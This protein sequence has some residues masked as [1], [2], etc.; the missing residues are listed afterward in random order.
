M[1]SKNPSLPVLSDVLISVSKDKK[2]LMFSATNLDLGANFTLKAKIEDGEE[3][4]AVKAGALAQFLTNTT[5]D[6][7]VLLEIK[8]NVLVVKTKSGNAKFAGSLAE[9]FPTINDLN[10]PVI[11]SLDGSKISDGLKSV[12]YSAS[13]SQ[14]KPELS[15]VFIYPDGD[16]LIFVSTDSF[17]LAEKKVKN[18]NIM[19]D[20]DGFVIPTKNALEISRIMETEDEVFEVKFGGGQVSF[21]SNELNLV[22]RV[23]EGNFPDYKQIIPKEQKTEAVF[24]KEDLVKALKAS[25]VF[26][27]SFNQIT[28]EFKPQDKKLEIF[29]KNK[30]VGEGDVSIS[31][32]LSGENAEIGFNYKYLTDCLPVIKSDSV[33]V[34]LFGVGKPAI[35]RGVSDNTFMYLV[36]PMNRQ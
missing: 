35:I 26:S 1:V 16:N 32:A 12:V 2:S 14:I 11:F 8:D 5:T 4:I 19:N 17:R 21:L 9:D 7:E 20:F 6:K 28:F 22:S 30:G 25:T 15:G 13:T 36:M 29:S 18:K 34:S 3:R 23:V 31:A 33:S 24:L 10:Q 27:D